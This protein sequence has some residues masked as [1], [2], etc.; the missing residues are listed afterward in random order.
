M[1]HLHKEGIISKSAAIK[2][3]KDAMNCF[4]KEENMVQVKDPVV[5]VGDIHG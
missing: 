4:K 5:F 1:S 2:L 3:I